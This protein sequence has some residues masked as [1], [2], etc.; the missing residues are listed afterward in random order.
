M[1]SKPRRRSFRRSPLQRAGFTL[2]E[3][4][5]VVAIIGVLAGILI[6]T[7]SFAVEK[8][9]QAHCTNNLREVARTVILHQEA[10]GGIPSGDGID[11][12]EELH[13]QGDGLL[14]SKLL[15][16]RS[17]SETAASRGQTLQTSN[18]S[19][20]AYQSATAPLTSGQLSQ[21]ATEIPIA[22]DRDGETH[23]G[24]YV[25]AFFDGRV[26]KIEQVKFESEQGTGGFMDG[27]T[28]QSVLVE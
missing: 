16:C 25:V 19:Y 1:R 28:L 23:G 26:E 27:K 9:N 6:P 22:A 20:R 17:S 10:N 12:L 13:N 18:I 7:I 11:F 4:M 24:V 3:L 21:D 8:A 14:K 5:V 2:I 15:V